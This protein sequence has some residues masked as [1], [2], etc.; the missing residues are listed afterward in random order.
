MAAPAPLDAVELV[1]GRC[2]AAEL[3]HTEVGISFWGG[4]DPLTG[5]VIDHT[6]P[7]HGVCI[8]DKI[9]A[10]PNG[11][12]APT[13]HSYFYR[14]VPAEPGADNMPAGPAPVR[15]WSSN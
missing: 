6:H 13:T 3:I 11:R 7:L 4:V 8:S 9:L 1:G 2:D 14:L 15:R 5:V 10:V 12:Y